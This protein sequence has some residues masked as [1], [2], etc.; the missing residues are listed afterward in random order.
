M[1][2]SKKMVSGWLSDRIRL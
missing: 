2:K 1:S